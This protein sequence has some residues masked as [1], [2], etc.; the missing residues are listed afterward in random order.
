MKGAKDRGV[1]FWKSRYDE[2]FKG[3]IANF[4]I[5][6]K[7]LKNE[8]V[9]RDIFLNPIFLPNGEVEEI[10][11]IATDITEKKRA[12]TALKGSEEKFRNIFPSFQ[13]I[14]F[15]RNMAGIISILSPSVQEVLGFEQKELINKKIT[16]YFILKSKISDLFK[17]LFEKNQIQNFEG[18]VKTSPSER[19]GF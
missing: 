12:G 5:S 1:E 11:V 8:K 2:A 9:W 13:D 6:Q 15:R 4:Q 3:K 16:D 14:Y 19:F 18:S 17:N 7:T 10:S